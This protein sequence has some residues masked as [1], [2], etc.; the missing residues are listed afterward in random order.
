VATQEQIYDALKKAHAAGDTE[1]ATKLANYIRS[2]QQAFAPTTRKEGTAGIGEAFMGG[3]KGLASSS[4]TALQAPFIGGEDA[5]LKGIER[6]EQ[7]TERPGAS[8]DAVKQAYKKDGIFSAAGEALSQIP[9]ALAEQ[10]PF[11]GAMFAGARLGA[12][13]GPYGALAGSLLAPFLMSSGAAMERKAT[14]QLS[15]G[16]SSFRIIWCE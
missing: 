9:G 1:N 2:S 5:A 14:E 8:L 15:K 11:I 4:L 3:L 10:S 6:G 16:K 7:M 13:A 12:A